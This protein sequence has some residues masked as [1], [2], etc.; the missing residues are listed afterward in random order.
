MTLIRIRPTKEIQIINYPKVLAIKIPHAMHNSGLGA[1]PAAGIHARHT[2]PVAVD[3]AGLDLA[4]FNALS[5][6]SLAVFEPPSAPI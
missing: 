4:N 3:I 1:E 5:K 6:A 2:I